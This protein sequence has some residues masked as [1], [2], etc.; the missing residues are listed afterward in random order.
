MTHFLLIIIYIS[1]I[2]LG[3]PDGLLGAAW[4][5]MYG[6]LMVPVSYAGTISMI[7]TLGTVF[8]S[9]SSDYL[10]YKLGT[11]RITAI[12]TGMT[13]FALLGFSVSNSYL[14]LCLMAIPYGL[15]AGGIDAAI[16]NYVALH[17]S[18]KH[19]SWLHCMWG[20]GAMIGP[21]IMGYILS[22]GQHWSTGYRYVGFLQLTLTTVLIFTLPIW[23]GR[24]MVQDSEDPESMHKS[25]PLPLSQ[26]IQ[27]PGAKEIM[28][29]FFCHCAL[30]QTALLWAGSY[31]VL[32]EGFGNEIAAFYASA[33]FIGVTIGRGICGFITERFTDTQLIR[34]GS[35]ITGVGL[36][37]M[38]LPLHP[39]IAVFGYILVGL[40]CAPIYPCIIHATPLLFGPE[41][42]Q[43]LIGVQMAS[44]YIGSTV[45]PPIFGLIAEHIH[46][47]LLPYIL[48]VTLI[49]MA[50]M[51]EKL[52]RKLHIK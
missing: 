14:M 39:Y 52:L 48:A 40:G 24:I 50:I 45:M 28:I 15:G 5:S 10:T 27:I 19:M 33:Y 9:L 32:N 22:G 20:L 4:P 23:K 8:S 42:S 35:I 18:S 21:Y 38:M 26:I 36:F 37:L 49:L 16:N 11:G 44:A 12:S 29:A 34:I 1:F 47:G 13:A 41:R 7:I 43:S 46:I 6:E 2:G 25:E 31:F 17:Y 30:E 3:L 51:Y